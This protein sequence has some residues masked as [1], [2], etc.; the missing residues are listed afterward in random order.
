MLITEFIVLDKKLTIYI[1]CLLL[2]ALGCVIAEN[3]HAKQPLPPFAASI[4]DGY[5]V[6]G[7]YATLDLCKQLDSAC[8]IALDSLL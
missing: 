8:G 6:I 1:F 7:M 3:V 4:K 2:D 5:A